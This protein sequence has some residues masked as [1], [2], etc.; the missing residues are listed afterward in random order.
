MTRAGGVRVGHRLGGRRTRPGWVGWV[1]IVGGP[2]Q[3]A[4]GHPPVNGAGQRPSCVRRPRRHSRSPSS[5]SCSAVR[6]KHW[7]GFRGT[8]HQSGQQA[9]TLAA[10]NLV[11]NHLNNAGDRAHE[12]V[13]PAHRASRR[14]CSRTA[15][16]RFTFAQV[17]AY[18]WTILGSI[19]TA[20]PQLSGR[21]PSY[22]LTDSRLVILRGAAPPIRT[23][24]GAI[25]LS[26]RPPLM[27]HDGQCGNRLLPFLLR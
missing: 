11:R 10:P 25:A 24:I 14:D 7:S 17:K 26:S 4:P 19:R 16:N 12:G 18:R 22:A 3:N 15:N 21:T 27:D 8:C 9:G 1:Q 20:F 6:T 13:S 2:P 23:G 5:P